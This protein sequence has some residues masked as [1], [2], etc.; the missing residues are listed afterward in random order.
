M[1]VPSDIEVARAQTPKDIRLLAEEIG[2]LRSELDEF[3]SKK[4]KV[5]LALLDRL[6]N[7]KDAKYVVVTGNDQYFFNS[8]N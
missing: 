4:G 2:L 6:K 5:S 7:R 1:K 8:V 3:G